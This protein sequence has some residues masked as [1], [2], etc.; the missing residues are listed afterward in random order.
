MA[1][2]R[3]FISLAVIVALAA[4]TLAGVLGMKVYK[5]E[6]QANT[7]TATVDSLGSGGAQQAQSAAAAAGTLTGTTLASNVVSSSLTSVGDLTSL[8]VDGATRL[9]TSLSGLLQGASGAVTAI[10]GTTGQFPYYNGTNTLLAT[11][12]IFL[13]SSSKVGIGSSTPMYS[14]SLG[15]GKSVSATES[16]LATSTS[17][18]INPSNGPVQL[19]R[20]G[21][22]ATTITAAGFIP[23]TKVDLTIC[24]PN[25]TAG[26]LTWTGFHVFGTA[27]TQTTTADKCDKYVLG[28]T[29]ATSTSAAT[30]IMYYAQAGAGLQ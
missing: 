8:N 15:S 23:G 11:S 30:G 9:A 24:N 20:M 29:Q 2:S 5:V 16:D 10:T 13:A 7:L 22:A 14:L 21:V 25:S 18:T 4:L 17:M 3:G 26:A 19:M 28:M 1:R 12:S 6:R 27:P